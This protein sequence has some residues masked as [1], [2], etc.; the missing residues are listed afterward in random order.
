[1]RADPTDLLTLPA[2]GV[3]WLAWRSA[4]QHP[5]ASAGV[6]ALRT[7]VVLP[8]ALI[9]VVATS[10]PSYPS[11]IVA[12]VDG[13]RL[14]AGAANLYHDRTPD[15]WSVSSDGGAT[16]VQAPET[17]ERKFA[18]PVRPATVRQ[19]CAGPV[20]YRTVAGHLR[21]EHSA[22]GG[23]TWSVAWQITDRQRAGMLR[24]YPG[25]EDV[26]KD[27]SSGSIAVQ[28]QPG[29]GHVVLAANGRDGFVVRHPDG[30]WE[31]IGHAGTGYFGAD[32]LA[33]PIRYADGRTWDVV[34]A[35]LLTVALAFATVSVGCLRAAQRLHLSAV[36]SV[37]TFLLIAPVALLLSMTLGPTDSVLIVPIW[38]MSFVAVLATATVSTT[39]TVRI[40][41]RPETPR[42]W[43]VTILG[44]G[45]LSGALVA[46]VF[47][48][49]IGN[50]LTGVPSI[51]VFALAATVPGSVLAWHAARR[52]ATAAGDGH[53]PDPPYPLAPRPGGR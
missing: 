50:H 36:W 45:L 46:G 4:T 44:A 31:R 24:T 34:L 6:R 53:Y 10:A 48:L 20:C 35:I 40:A 51:L 27:L 12:D 43:S 13:D 17:V 18:D 29:N 19:S 14:V 11:A 5:T 7:A 23:R 39:Q 30:R 42:A 41:T 16:W 25:I 33:D 8:L 49:W 15:M 37:L 38:L 28:P 22:D 9:G 3:S 2:L 1:M 26:D 47:A 21:I 32:P 52:L